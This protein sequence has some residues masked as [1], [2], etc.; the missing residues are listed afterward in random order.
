MKLLLTYLI[1]VLTIPGE[2]AAT[3]ESFKIL[4][5]G[6][7]T[8]DYV[9]FTPDMSPFTDAFSLCSWIRKLRSQSEYP[10]WFSYAASNSLNNEILIYDDG[11]SNNVF[12][13]H[14]AGVKS[15]AG[16]VVGDWYHYCIC[17]D[18]T[19]R[20]ANIYHNG[21][22]TGSYSTPSGRRLI[23]NGRVVLGQDQ[24]TVGGGFQA[25]QAFG[26]ELQKLN[27]YS[28]KLS[29]SEVGDMYSAGRCSDTV[30]KSHGQSRQLKWEEVLQQPRNGNVNVVDTCTSEVAFALQ[31]VKEQLVEANKE[32]QK[33]RSELTQTKASKDE[34]SEE[35]N[36]TISHLEEKTTEV[37]NLELSLENTTDQL[38]RMET[39]LDLTETNL[40]E[41]ETE[42][43]QTETK[44][45]QTETKFHQTETK[46]NQTETKLHQTETKLNQ[47]ETK[48]NQTETKLNQTETKLN[49]TETKLN[50]TETKL[51][52]TNRNL[53]D[54]TDRL[55]N[56]LHELRTKEQEAEECETR[57][58]GINC[59]R[60]TNS[61]HWDILY[62]VYF[63]N[64]VITEELLEILDNSWEKL[65]KWEV[66]K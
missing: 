2:S 17:W 50:Q 64:K 41:T 52:E 4:K 16:I 28:K 46:L 53:A 12:H 31:A 13:S 40:N 48:L 22:Q 33:I 18:Y 37:E 32:L 54:T 36:R 3:T 51:T 44:L 49:Q 57:I 10:T 24:D 9:T 45:H 14:N 60:A 23:V 30:E 58:S 21:T 56:T 26:G 15:R 65:G 66:E 63:Y 19:S 11:R 6:A 38:T 1:A 27:I 62:T 29:S 47:T 61:S 55:N 59:Y 43:H 35:L 5:F 34:I 8:S 20:T 39:I 7:T 25:N 42:L